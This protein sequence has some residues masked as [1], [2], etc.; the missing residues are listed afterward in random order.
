M[1]GEKYKHLSSDTKLAYMVL[2]D[3]LEYSLRN[4][5]VDENDNVYFVFTNEELKNYL[6]AQIQKL[7]KLKK[8]LK[9]LIY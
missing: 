4:N 3:R 9:V 5:W 8:S 2:K 6:T 7:Q 1:Y